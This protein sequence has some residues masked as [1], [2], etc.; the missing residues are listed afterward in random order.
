MLVAQIDTLLQS[1]PMDKTSTIIINN[2]SRAIKLEFKLKKIYFQPPHL[3]TDNNFSS[4][5]L[6]D[7]LGGKGY[8]MTGTCA[9]DNIPPTLNPYTHHAKV[10]NASHPRCK[11][12]QFENPVVAIQQQP[13][14]VDS[15]LPYT[16]TFVSFQS[17]GGT[18]IIGVNNLPSVH[19]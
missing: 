5:L 18:N 3:A 10:P 7:W 2:P 17:T 11:A 9:R 1:T 14:A 15:D 4:D 8:G 19:L 12:M 13:S 16:K 6:M